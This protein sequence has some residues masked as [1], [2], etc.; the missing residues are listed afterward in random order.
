M[1]LAWLSPSEWHALLE[2]AVRLQPANPVTWTRLGHLHLYVLD[3]PEEALRDYRAAYYLDPA[4][5]ASAANFIAAQ[6]AVAA[7]KKGP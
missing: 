2:R 1:R 4:A 5:P 7:R 3:Q 6:R